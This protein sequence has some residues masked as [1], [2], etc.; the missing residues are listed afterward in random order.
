MRASRG[1][2]LNMWLTQLCEPVPPSSACASSPTRR[3]L[4]R[5]AACAWAKRTA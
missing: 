4:A 2:A 5:S 1:T 3:R